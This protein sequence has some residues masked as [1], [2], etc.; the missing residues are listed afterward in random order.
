M[1][2]NNQ[3]RTN[4]G[5]GIVDYIPNLTTWHSENYPNAE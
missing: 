2:M 1:D 4:L 3:H 5:T